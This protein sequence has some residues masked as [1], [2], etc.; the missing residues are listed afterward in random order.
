MGKKFKLPWYVR[1]SP[2][3]AAGDTEEALD[4]L[5]AAARS[6]VADEF[7]A[8]A[9]NDIGEVWVFHYGDKVAS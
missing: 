4:L 3:A 9:A 5:R 6:S 2:V 8:V 7:R 1:S